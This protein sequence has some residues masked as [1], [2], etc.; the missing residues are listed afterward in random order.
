[1]V[2]PVKISAALLRAFLQAQFFVI[3]R[4]SIGRAFSL[5]DVQF[6]QVLPLRLLFFAFH[7]QI[8]FSFLGRILYY[9]QQFCLGTTHGF[10]TPFQYHVCQAQYHLQYFHQLE[11]LRQ[12]GLQIRQAFSR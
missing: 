2:H 9:L 5:K 12:L 8:L 4:R 3:H 7:L 6:A 10:E 11:F 1:M